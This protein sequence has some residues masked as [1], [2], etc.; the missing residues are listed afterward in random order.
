[1]GAKWSKLAK[2][3]RE[4][5]HKEGEENSK[6]DTGSKQYKKKTQVWPAASLCKTRERKKRG[7]PKERARRGLAGG[8]IAKTLRAVDNAPTRLDHGVKGKK[9]IGCAKDL[10]Q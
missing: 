10:Y 7:P 5:P 8:N 1:V 9:T 3:C 6:R 4:V 2:T